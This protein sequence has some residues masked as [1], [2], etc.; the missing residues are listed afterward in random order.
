VLNQGVSTTQAHE[1]ENLE[2]ENRSFTHRYKNK[3][4]QIAKTNNGRNKWK[5]CLRVAQA[6]LVLQRYVIYI[7]D[8]QDSVINLDN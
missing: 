3:H 5:Y 2:Q 1:Y 4:K 7:Q 8:T 6:L